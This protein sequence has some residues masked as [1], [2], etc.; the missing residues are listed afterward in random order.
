MTETHNLDPAELK[1][2]S[3]Q[4]FPPEVVDEKSMKVQWSTDLLDQ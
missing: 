1:V 2:P 3:T 4:K